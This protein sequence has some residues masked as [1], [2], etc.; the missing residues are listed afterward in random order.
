MHGVAPWRTDGPLNSAREEGLNELGEAPPPYIQDT[1]IEERRLP[2]GSSS[3][4]ELPAGPAIPLRT[5][6][7]DEQDRL[8]PPDYESSIRDS[9]TP[10]GEL[11]R[12][13]SIFPSPSVRDVRISHS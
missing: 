11:S 3:T 2:V 8:K 13:G 9:L 10:S 4:A 5:L 7:R 12:P 1:H 6:S